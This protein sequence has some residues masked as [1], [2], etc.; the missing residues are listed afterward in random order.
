MGLSDERRGAVRRFILP[1]PRSYNF[2]EDPRHPQRARFPVDMSIAS[3]PRLGE[4]LLACFGGKEEGI[5]L[6]PN[7][8]VQ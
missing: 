8:L 2:R 1:A 7:C 3:Y 5:P 4:F 6:N